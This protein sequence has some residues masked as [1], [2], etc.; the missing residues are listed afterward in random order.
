MV[1]VAA[2]RV[3]PDDEEKLT[4]KQ[5]RQWERRL[6]RPLADDEVGLVLSR[7][8]IGATQDDHRKHRRQ[9]HAALKAKRARR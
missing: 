8:L 6:K 5:R 9:T 2:E 7:S 3:M 4:A 1:A